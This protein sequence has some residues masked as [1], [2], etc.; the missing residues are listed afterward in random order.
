MQEHIMK[1]ALK[2]AT[3]VAPAALAAEASE[4]ADTAFEPSRVTHSG[5]LHVDAPPEHA[6]PLFTAPGERLWAP[7]WD[8]VIL[9]GGDGLERGSVWL[10]AHGDEQTIWFVA[11]YDPE[12][13]HAHYARITPTSRAGSV[14]VFV[15]SDG[16]G[17]SDVTVTYDLTALNE[18]GNRELAGF[19]GEHYAHML[20]EWER[21]IQEANLEY[22][23]SFAD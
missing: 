20:M 13:F 1:K 22:P 14:E 12:S 17:G 23:L 16:D 15:R 21:L 10:T 19:D 2:V 6:F 4:V 7:G 9:S 11:D 8:P 3:P 5:S 18:A